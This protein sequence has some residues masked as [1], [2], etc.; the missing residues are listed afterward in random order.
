MP[1]IIPA[2]H[3]IKKNREAITKEKFSART[4]TWL[5]ES[6][7]TCHAPRQIQ[8]YTLI[9][10]DHRCVPNYYLIIV[11]HIFP[12]TVTKPGLDEKFKNGG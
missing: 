9:T 7:M 1:L 4:L 8:R 11:N 3:V 5:N 12:S 6:S 10:R 2:S